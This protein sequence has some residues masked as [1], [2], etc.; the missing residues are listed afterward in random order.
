MENNTLIKVDELNKFLSD[1]I[2]NLGL[3]CVGYLNFSIRNTRILITVYGGNNGK[4]DWESYFD[5]MKTIIGEFKDSWLVKLD[6]DCPDDVW[7]LKIGWPIDNVRQFFTDRLNEILEGKE[8]NPPQ[9]DLVG[10][11]EFV[12]KVDDKNSYMVVSDSPYA[13]FKATNGDENEFIKHIESLS[14]GD[15]FSLYL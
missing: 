8:E 9:L 14:V 15:R 11:K 7:H 10:S 3:N 13:E 2:L 1:K 6:N 5:Q 12:I 4:P